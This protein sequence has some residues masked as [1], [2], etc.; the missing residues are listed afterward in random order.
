MWSQEDQQ[1][2]RWRRAK[3]G[4]TSRAC[5]AKRLATWQLGYATRRQWF[6][7]TPCHVGLGENDARDITANLDTLN[8][9]R[10]HGRNRRRVEHD[11]APLLQE[12]LRTHCNCHRQKACYTGVRVSGAGAI[13]RVEGVWPRENASATLPRQIVAVARM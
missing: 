13:R 2:P 10:G 11:H 6:R 1:P 5:C 8:G 9:V 3:R 7:T 4:P 12:G